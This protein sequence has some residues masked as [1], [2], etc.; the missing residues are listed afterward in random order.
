M[1]E[2]VS[3]DE[4]PGLLDGGGR[5]VVSVHPGSAQIALEVPGGKVRTERA[6][7]CTIEGHLERLFALPPLGEQRSQNESVGGH[8]RRGDLRTLHPLEDRYGRIAK[9]A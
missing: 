8:H 5:H 3:V 9:A 1:D 6:Q 2:V 7:L 4:A